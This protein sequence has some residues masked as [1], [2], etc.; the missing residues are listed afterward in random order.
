MFSVTNPLKALRE[1]RAYYER[2]NAIKNQSRREKSIIYG[3]QALVQQLGG[4][5]RNTRDW[6]IKSKNPKRSAN[7]LQGQLDR[8]AGQNLYY[9]TPSKFKRGV[10]KV[11]F[12]GDDHRRET[13]DDIG[14]ADFSPLKRS[15]K[16]VVRQGLR[17]AT[18]ASREMDA[19]RAL[20]QK[21]F[22]FRSEKDRQD[23]ANIAAYRK[24][25]KL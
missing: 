25:R 18:L 24:F 12:I 15:D 5:A 4:L 20:K 9:R 22:E 23:L 16:F 21:Q 10:Q 13:K 3:G 19:R 1:A 6:D 17:Y 8:R 2:D 14:I 7:F 11:V